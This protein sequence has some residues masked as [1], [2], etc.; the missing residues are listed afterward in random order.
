MMWATMAE[1]TKGMKSMRRH[2][3]YEYFQDRFLRLAVVCRLCG[4]GFDVFVAF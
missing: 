3:Q 4:S 1:R 2:L